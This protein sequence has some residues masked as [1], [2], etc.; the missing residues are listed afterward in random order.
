MHSPASPDE[1]EESRLRRWRVK[2]S[3]KTQALTRG[4]S[5]SSTATTT[6]GQE[7][8]FSKILAHNNA[9]ACLDPTHN[10]HIRLRLASGMGESDR[11]KSSESHYLLVVHSCST[12]QNLQF[13]SAGSRGRRRRRRRG[14]GRV[15]DTIRHS[16]HV[17]SL[18]P[19][20]V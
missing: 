1:Q 7:S 20:V 19:P 2:A 9:Y 10:H 6:T 3:L 17:T 14:G 13:S 18:P 15:W 12:R 5:A 8:R 16:S 11:P 4:D